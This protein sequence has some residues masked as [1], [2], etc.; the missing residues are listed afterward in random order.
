MEKFVLSQELEAMVKL[1]G[2]DVSKNI[3][4]VLLHLLDKGDLTP[5]GYKWAEEKITKG[6]HTK[7]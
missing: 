7:V 6:I 3:R 5:E 1:A 4:L 2:A